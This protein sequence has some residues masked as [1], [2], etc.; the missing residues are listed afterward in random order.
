MGK[1]RWVKYRGSLWVPHRLSSPAPMGSYWYWVLTGDYIL[2]MA[3]RPYRGCHAVEKWSVVK[4]T[5]ALRGH[6]L[7]H[8]ERGS[9]KKVKVGDRSSVKHLAAVETEVLRD[10]MPIIEFQALL[11]YEDGSPRQAGYIGT[12]TNGSVWFARA[13]DKDADATLTMEGRT[14]DEAMGLL[15]LHLAAENAPWEPNSRKKKKGG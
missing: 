11:Q 2:R 6:I 14:W 13:T 1:E 10:M 4:G 3:F 9:V 15:S 12:W 5:I 7:W 8:R